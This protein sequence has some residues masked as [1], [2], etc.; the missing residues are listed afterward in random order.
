MAARTPRQF[1]LGHLSLAIPAPEWAIRR[2]ADAGLIPHSKANRLRI[3]SEADIPEI[4]RVCQE[5]GYLAGRQA[6]G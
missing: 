5:R 1:T 3:F 6:N 4:R 2:L